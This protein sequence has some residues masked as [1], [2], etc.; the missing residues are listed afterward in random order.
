MLKDKRLSKGISQREM[1]RA[2]GIYF[3]QYSRGEKGE[4]NFKVNEL[5]IIAKK[6]GMSIEDLFS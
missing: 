5:P 2:L 1:A 6:L 4:R 3:S